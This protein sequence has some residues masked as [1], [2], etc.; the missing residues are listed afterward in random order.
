[1]KKAVIVE[2]ETDGR[3][4][5]LPERVEL[6]DQLTEY[7]NK[8]I[9]DFL[10]DTYGWLVKDWKYDL[11]YYVIYETIYDGEYEYGCTSIQSTYKG[12][13]P[14]EEQLIKDMYGDEVTESSWCKG[15]WEFNHDYRMISIRSI[16]KVESEKDLL[17]LKKYGIR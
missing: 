8:S 9:C 11:D 1:M 5:D 17:I 14:K 3:N 7:T 13:E 15:R 2:W 6:P 12:Q 4:P 16:R 10:S